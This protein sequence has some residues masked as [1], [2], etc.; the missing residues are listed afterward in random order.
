MEFLAF[1]VQN[2][3]QKTGNWTGVFL[4]TF[5]EFPKLIL[6]FYALI[7]EPGTLKTQSDL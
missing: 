2:T 4:N 3:G 1:L 5:G 6:R 7:L